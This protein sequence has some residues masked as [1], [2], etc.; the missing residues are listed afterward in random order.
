MERD[1][2]MKK[3]LLNVVITAVAM[4][5]LLTATACDKKNDSGAQ[6]SAPNSSAPSSQPASEPEQPKLPTNPFTGAE[7]SQADQLNRPLAVMIN[8]IEPALPQSGIGSADIVFELPVEGA[9][10]RL[11]AV[12]SDNTN[13]PTV[14][15]IRSSRHDFVE[16]I[17]PFDPIYLHFGYSESAK[18]AIAR[19]GINN[20]NGIEMANVAFYQDKAKLK[21]KSSEHT[22]FSN[23]DLLKAGVDNKSYADKLTAP[24][25][26]MFQFAEGSAMANYPEATPANSALIK[27]SGGANAGFEYSAETDRYKKSQNGKTH[28]DEGMGSTQCEYKNVLVMYTTVGMMVDGKHKEV[29]LSSGKGYYISEG[30]K[31][32]VTFK[33][34]TVDSYLKVYDA[35]GNEV[36]LNVGNTWVC[37]APSDMQAQEVIE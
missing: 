8:N 18:E 27:F 29:E 14:G 6:S 20:V 1:T 32:D 23:Y 11:M 13:M 25:E 4:A 5:L 22:W 7:V 30:R 26:P 31:I 37:I 24:I 15:S 17:K 3:K 28:I 9:A 21:V 12:F 16:L 10:T 35:A 19:E 33:K 36:K 34:P 2:H